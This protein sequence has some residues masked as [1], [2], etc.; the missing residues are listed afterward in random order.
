V[1]KSGNNF[2][3]CSGKTN[4]KSVFSK[5]RSEVSEGKEKVLF[6]KYKNVLSFS[7]WCNDIQKKDYVNWCLNKSQ[8][9]S[10]SN[11]QVV[12]PSSLSQPWGRL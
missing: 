3:N 2:I 10:F 4:L 1:N 6:G 9:L 12:F 8:E 5:W 11:F 7:Q